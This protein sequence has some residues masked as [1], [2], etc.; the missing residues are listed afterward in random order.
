MSMASDSMQRRIVLKGTYVSGCGYASPNWARIRSDHEEE[1]PKIRLCRPGTFNV[2]VDTP[3]RPPSEDEY[4]RRARQ[5]GQRD[6]RYADGNHLSPL[7][8]VVEINRK[9]AE[10]WIYRGGH[11]DEFLELVSADQLAH[12][13]ALRLGDEVAMV[14]VEFLEEGGPGMP[15]APPV[16]T[17]T[18]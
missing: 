1:F 5:R 3:Y 18:G 16:G 7:A 17:G 10:A 14:I 15:A 11:G 6:G 4:R 12:C 2:W 13:H 8:K 9:P